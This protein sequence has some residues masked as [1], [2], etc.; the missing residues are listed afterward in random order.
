MCVRVRVSSWHSYLVAL[1]H[2]DVSVR[3]QRHELRMLTAG[4]GVVPLATA[5]APAATGSAG[6]TA[7]VLSSGHGGALREGCSVLVHVIVPAIAQAVEHAREIGLDILP[8]LPSTSTAPKAVARGHSSIDML[9]GYTT[10]SSDLTPGSRGRVASQNEE[11]RDTPAAYLAC[12]TQRLCVWAVGRG[13]ALVPA[14][15]LDHKLT[16]P[17]QAAASDAFRRHVA[18]ASIV[19]ASR[20]V[21]TAAAASRAAR[22]H[23]LLSR[24]LEVR[25]KNAIL[26]RVD[27]W[28][29]MP[30]T[31]T[32]RVGVSLQL[33]QSVRDA[34]TASHGGSGLPVMKCLRQVF[35]SVVLYVIVVV[36]VW[37][38]G[39][40]AC[41][42]LFCR[43]LFSCY[44]F[45]SATTATQHLPVSSVVLYH[46]RGTTHSS[47]TRWPRYCPR[48][49]CR[50]T[51]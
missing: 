33:L 35:D 44:W 2:Q 19:E 47:A 12:G 42:C 46:V 21:S 43:W 14:N 36:V 22:V 31:H 18:L 10:D 30:A 11:L 25:V 6:G 1:D 29:D 9:F 26:R 16:P 41:V 4:S 34:T 39:C 15:R 24:T 13:T 45:P 51:V 17:Q 40:G 23:A 37:L 50:C 20:A 49:C 32:T 48:Q 8:E 5:R 3:V 27:A 38:C 7:E 28:S